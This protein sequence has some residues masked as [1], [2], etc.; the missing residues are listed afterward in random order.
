MVV[1]EK[2]KMKYQLAEI[3]VLV[4]S[5]FDYILSTA[6]LLRNVDNF[7]ILGFPK[8]FSDIHSLIT[9]TLGGKKYENCIEVNSFGQEEKIRSLDFK[10]IYEFQINI[11][12]N[13]VDQLN[14]NI[15]SEFLTQ[16]M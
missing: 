12:K 5:V 13:K 2:I 1:L 10:K 15:R 11:D 16:K 4:E 9:I 14:G 3:C 7:E 6:N 8:V